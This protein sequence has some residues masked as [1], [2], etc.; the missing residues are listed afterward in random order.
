VC[1]SMYV[2]MCTCAFIRMFVR[3]FVCVY[4]YRCVCMYVRICVCACVPTG[5]SVPA[6]LSVASRDAFP[7]NHARN[8]RN[9]QTNKCNP[10]LAE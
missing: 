2:C 7:T 3:M 6:L 10:G 1:V 5:G 4:V 8:P 9:K